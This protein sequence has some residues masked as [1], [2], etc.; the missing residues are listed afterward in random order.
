MA[1]PTILNAQQH[2]HRLLLAEI[3]H[4]EVVRH[5]V[6][7]A[8]GCLIGTDGEG[9]RRVEERHVGVVVWSEIAQLLVEMTENYKK[10]LTGRKPK[11][12]PCTHC[13]MVR[14]DDEEYARFMARYKESGVYAKFRILSTIYNQIVKEMHVNFSVEIGRTGGI[15]D[16]QHLQQQ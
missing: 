13:V 4:V 5:D 15:A 8:A 14:F 11:L 1:S 2:I 16:N 6:H 3:G 10:K 7:A 12:N 9:V